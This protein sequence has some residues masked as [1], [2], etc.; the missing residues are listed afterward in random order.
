MP[1]QQWKSAVSNRVILQLVLQAI[2]RSGLFAIEQTL[3]RSKPD[4]AFQ[5]LRKITRRPLACAWNE[6]QTSHG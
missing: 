1:V 5:T 4:A 3:A 6:S 2:H